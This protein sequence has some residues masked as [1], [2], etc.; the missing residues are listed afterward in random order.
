MVTHSPI[1][2][3]LPVNNS[4]DRT[5]TSVAV[6]VGTWVIVAGSIVAIGIAVRQGI[7][8]AAQTGAE[9][10]LENGRHQVEIQRARAIGLA[11]RAQE[12]APMEIELEIAA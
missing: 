1:D 9:A 2:S 11:A 6:T 10:L 12:I 5:A 8:A 3:G 7:G 4:L